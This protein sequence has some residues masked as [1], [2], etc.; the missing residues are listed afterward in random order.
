MD[1][2]FSCKICEEGSHLK[3]DHSKKMSN[4]KIILSV[5]NYGV[6]IR[7]NF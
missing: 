4:T 6:I 7:E 5:K 2:I 3:Y 1:K